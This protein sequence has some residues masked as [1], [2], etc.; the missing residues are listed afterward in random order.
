VANFV[1]EHVKRSIKRRAIV[2]AVCESGF[3]FVD[4][5]RTGSSTTRTM[6]S[7][8]FPHMG[9]RL[10][11]GELSLSAAAL[12]PV[13]LPATEWRQ[14]L[15]L[16]VWDSLYKFSIVRNPWDRLTSIYKYRVEIEGAKHRDFADFVA[17][18][19]RYRFQDP[20]SILHWDHWRRSQWSYVADADDN[21][22]VDHLYRFEEAP[23]IFFDIA[24]R[25]GVEVLDLPHCEQTSR[26]DWR[27]L[28][29]N[30]EVSLA[31]AFVV[32][33]LRRLKYDVQDPF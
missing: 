31:H 3:L 20:N 14:I 13:H 12:A 7:K 16:R 9:K 5:P 6:L 8:A 18:L 4:I 28:Y 22:L 24:R 33:D 15:G 26:A 10:S 1:V 17:D 23:Q 11:G 32:E 2:R 19:S 21:V 27:E 30:A 29:R 25:V